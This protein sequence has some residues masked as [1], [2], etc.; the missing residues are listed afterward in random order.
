MSVPLGILADLKRN[1]PSSDQVLGQGA[2]INEQRWRDVAV[3][4]GDP[5]ITWALNNLPRPIT[6]NVIIGLRHGVP[7]VRR[8][9]V[10]IASLM[11][12]FGITG[13]R[14][15]SW[16]T[17]ISSFLS[18]GLDPILTQCETHLTNGAIDQAYRLFTHP[19]RA[20]VE[21]ENHRGIGIPFITKVLYFLARNA[22]GETPTEYPMILDTKVSYALA[23]LTGYRLLVRPDDYRP[24]PDST[25][26]A[27][28]V[29]TMH[30]WASKLDV[31]PEAI[32][33]Y[34]WAEASKRGSPLWTAVDRVFSSVFT[35]PA[36]EESS[37][38][39]CATCG[40]GIPPAEASLPCPR[41]G[42]VDRK[43]TATDHASAVDEVTRLDVQI[44]LAPSSWQQIWVQVRHHLDALR[45]WYS[46]SQGTDVTELSAN[47]VAFFVS[48]YHLAEHISA[49]QA[50]PQSAR[51]G[52]RTYTRS[53]P[54]LKLAADITNTYKHSQ[55]H[56]GER[57][58][59]ITDLSIR[60]TG[61]VV[62]FTW[63]D[64]Q[65]NPH[66][67]DCLNLAEQAVTAWS[68]FLQG[69]GL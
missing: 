7:T 52:V 68:I 65:G 56:A 55:R 51:T 29:K 67:E 19:G 17:D 13:T 69:H 33:Y 62:T 6:R 47:S 21:Q 58:C 43:V 11:W 27:R 2:L 40:R 63:I 41:C 61:A 24:R 38:M 60:P 16:T 5:E 57:T 30:T 10:A 22:P 25:A 66:H 37:T 36:V 3:Q 54:S 39:S 45:G 23:Q 42:S 50:V 64:A 12:G 44:P 49:D 32:E 18:P 35:E 26:Y 4:I 14:W 31:L 9:R 46:G 34:L 48:C 8:R 20:G 28:Y 59:S 1:F 53:E 15:G